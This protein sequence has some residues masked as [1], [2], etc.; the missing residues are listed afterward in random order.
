MIAD[1]DAYLVREG[2]LRID[3]VEVQDPVVA[4]AGP[5][6][7][8]TLACPWVLTRNGDRVTSWDADF[9]DVV[10]DLIGQSVTRVTASGGRPHDPAFVLTEGYVL[11]VEADTDLDPWVLRL[12]G[13]TYVGSF[14]K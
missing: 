9:A 5:G 10:W 6:W 12:R 14:S 2:P 11:D 1:I 7:S 4:F 8:L 13:I 3:E